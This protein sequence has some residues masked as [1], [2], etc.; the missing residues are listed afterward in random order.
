MQS[1]KSHTGHKYQPRPTRAAEYHSALTAACDDL[2]GYVQAID[3]VRT[4]LLSSAY[5]SEMLSDS[6]IG[7][8]Y[9]LGIAQAI[10][11]PA[12]PKKSIWQRII[13]ILK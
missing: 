12:T 1:Y 9:W 4:G 8:R 13:S 10:R 7:C 2:R 11:C 6:L 3:Y 5:L